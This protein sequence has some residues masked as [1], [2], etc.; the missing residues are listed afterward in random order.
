MA[1]NWTAFLRD[2]RSHLKALESRGCVNPYFRGHGTATWPLLPGLARVPRTEEL[3]NRFYGRFWSQG[4]H[5]LPSGTSSW[6]ALFLMQHHGLPTRLLDWSESFAIALYFAVANANSDVAVWVLDPYSL[7]QKTRG[8]SQILDL[9]TSYPEGYERLFADAH[10]PYE[11]FPPS[12]VSVFSK[13]LSARM[14]WQ[15][16][17]F[18][19]H[20]E[21]D[22]PLETLHPDCTKQ[23]VL[24]IDSLGEARDFLQLASVNEF[25]AFP[26]LDGLARYLRH[27]ELGPR[28]GAA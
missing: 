17:V 24:G 22:T 21:L 9:N 1:N 4:G 15:R 7:N 11:G 16:A 18:T 26:D 3:E 5:L 20:R 28:S 8:E 14:Q 2:L 6:D 10:P 12:V 27:C 13:P 25:T 19:F 23:L